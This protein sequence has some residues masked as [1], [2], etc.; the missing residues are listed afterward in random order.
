MGV[1]LPGGEPPAL[2]AGGGLMCVLCAPA[3]HTECLVLREVGPWTQGRGLNLSALGTSMGRSASSREARVLKPALP[4]RW[5]DPFL[6]LR[7][8]TECCAFNATTKSFALLLD[9]LSNVWESETIQKWL[10]CVEGELL[11]R[12]PFTRGRPSWVALGR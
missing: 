9:S 1:R 2:T 8:C 5:D 6:C 7:F 3:R 4:S 11:T 12:N 10:R